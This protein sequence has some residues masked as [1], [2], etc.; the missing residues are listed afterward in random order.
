M[1][2][3]LSLYWHYLNDFQYLVKASREESTSVK[4]VGENTKPLC[5]YGRVYTHTLLVCVYMGTKMRGR[6]G[7]EEDALLR[8]S[9]T[10]SLFSSSV[11]FLAVGKGGK[12][13]P[14]T[15][16]FTATTTALLTQPVRILGA[17]LDLL[18]QWGASAS[19]P[20]PHGEI[21]SPRK[22]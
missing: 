20:P 11:S 18:P 15:T 10:R 1:V 2:L 17:P 5:E 9:H 14:T 22:H 21:S 4:G 16:T 19:P 3:P 8:C 7:G 12:S 13:G 6:G